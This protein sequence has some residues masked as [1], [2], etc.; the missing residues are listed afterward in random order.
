[1]DRPPRAGDPGNYNQFW[2]DRG[3]KVVSTRQSALVIDPPDGRV[4]A[5]TAAAQKQQKS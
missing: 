3:T 4:P 1:M 2:F 5:L